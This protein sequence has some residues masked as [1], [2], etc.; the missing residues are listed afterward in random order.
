MEVSASQLTHR[1]NQFEE[2]QFKQVM[3]FAGM[4]GAMSPGVGSDLAAWK[5]YSVGVRATSYGE[6]QESSSSASGDKRSKRWV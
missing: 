4:Y 6:M 3:L 5:D 1:R 2:A